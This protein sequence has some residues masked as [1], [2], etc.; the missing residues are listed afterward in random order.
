MFPKKNAPKGA[1]GAALPETRQTRLQSVLW[2]VAIVLANT[3]Q[4]LLAAAVVAAALWG[5]GA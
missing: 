4:T 1:Q 5:G 2:R 3:A